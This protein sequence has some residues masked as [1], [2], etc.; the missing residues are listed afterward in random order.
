ME[1]FRR[2]LRQTWIRRT[3]RLLTLTHTHP[4]FLSRLT[5]GDIK[6]HRDPEWVVRE[7]SYHD[8]AIKELND[9]VRK[10][11]ATAPYSVRRNYYVREVE[12]E[13]LY[14]DCA[15][16]ILAGI[17]TK[18]DGGFGGHLSL[19]DTKDNTSDRM[20]VTFALFDEGL[21]FSQLLQWWRVVLRRWQSFW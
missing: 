7:K 20:D 12:V 18:T 10:Y 6:A 16:E 21:G 5:L 9:L 2:L 13:K 14:V 3:L 17:G 15:E 4:T 19:A 1:T 8:A 11:N